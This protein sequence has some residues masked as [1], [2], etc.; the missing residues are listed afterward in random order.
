M[1]GLNLS[2]DTID[3]ISLNQPLSQAVKLFNPETGDK[4]EF[5]SMTQAGVYLNVA[6]QTI[7]SH[8]KNN[9]LLKGYTCALKKEEWS[10]SG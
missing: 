6:R 7:K 10:S 2:K 4:K 5:L 1:L 8:I 9:K 3:K